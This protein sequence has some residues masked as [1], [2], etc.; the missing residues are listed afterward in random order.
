MSPKSLILLST[1]VVVVI[2]CFSV[3]VIIASCF[4][5]TRPN[6]FPVTLIFLLM[7]IYLI[8]VSS[9]PPPFYCRSQSPPPCCQMVSQSVKSVQQSSIV[10][11]ISLCVF[12][13]FLC[14]TIYCFYRKRFYGCSPYFTFDQVFA[15]LPVIS[16][17]A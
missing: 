13:I 1:A 8:R 3:F 17:Q 10:F 5:I 4:T 12:S 11:Q 15:Q 9:N 7:L 2:A 16:Q 14:L 6:R